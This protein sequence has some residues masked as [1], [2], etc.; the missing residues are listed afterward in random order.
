MLIVHWT[1]TGSNRRSIIGFKI[2]LKIY[3]YH[4]YSKSSGF[5]T[6]QQTRGG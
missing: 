1:I 4:F 5:I 3:T 6:G 2:E